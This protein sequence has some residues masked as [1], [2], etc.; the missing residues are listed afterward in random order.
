M[1]IIEDIDDSYQMIENT[2]YKAKENKSIE[3]DL[4]TAIKAISKTTHELIEIIKSTEN[5]AS[6]KNLLALNGY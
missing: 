2:A 6:H 4:T 3:D 5:I 1:R